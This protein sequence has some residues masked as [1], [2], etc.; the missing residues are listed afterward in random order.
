MFSKFGIESLIALG[1]DLINKSIMD[2]FNQKDSFVQIEQHTIDEINM[3]LP[4]IAANVHHETLLN[5]FY[6]FVINKF[7]RA[8]SS[9]MTISFSTSSSKCQEIPNIDIENIIDVCEQLHIS[10]LNSK[11]T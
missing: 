10:F 3:H 9:A 1:N 4:H 7:P 8:C 11:F 2:S 6:T 5:L